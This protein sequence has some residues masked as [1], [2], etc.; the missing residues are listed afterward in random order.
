MKSMI[1][2]WKWS[3]W[4]Q[5]VRSS[6]WCVIFYAFGFSCLSFFF[7][8]GLIRLYAFDCKHTFVACHADHRR[9]RDPRGRGSCPGPA[10]HTGSSGNLEGVSQW[11]ASAGGPEGTHPV[12]SRL[13]STSNETLPASPLQAWAVAAGGLRCMTHPEYPV[14]RIPAPEITRCTPCGA[15]QAANQ[16]KLLCFHISYALFEPRGKS[17]RNGSCIFRPAH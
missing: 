1:E 3:D 9:S 16:T 5:H 17:G 2:K 4:C 8:T 13:L 7:T 12:A 11:N 6:H 14:V 15:P 10:L